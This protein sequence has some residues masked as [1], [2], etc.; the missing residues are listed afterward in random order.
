MNFLKNCTL[1]LFS[2]FS[3]SKCVCVHLVKVGNNRFP[4]VQTKFGKYI[5]FRES[6]TQFWSLEYTNR[7]FEVGRSV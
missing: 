5:I 7:K 1:A 2:V 6:R 4:C 3:V